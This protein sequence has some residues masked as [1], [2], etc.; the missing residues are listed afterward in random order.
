[1]TMEDEHH[2]QRFVAS[3][4]SLGNASLDDV[5]SS[6]SGDLHVPAE[7]AD[8]DFARE[9]RR[10]YTDLY[11]NEHIL[12]RFIAFYRRNKDTLSFPDILPD[13]EARRNYARWFI[14]PQLF[15]GI[16]NPGEGSSLLFSDIKALVGETPVDVVYLSPKVFQP[17]PFD[18]ED[19]KWFNLAKCACGMIKNGITIGNFSPMLWASGEDYMEAQSRGIVKEA[20]EAFEAVDTAPTYDRP[21]LAVSAREIDRKMLNAFKT[22][23][24]SRGVG[25]LFSSP[26]KESIPGFSFVGY[27]CA[28]AT[29][30]PFYTLDLL[31]WF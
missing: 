29:S 27:Y 11:P 6:F 15:L 23:S 8:D 14:S 16:H 30:P 7:N 1:M 4:V 5:F 9:F 22:F 26:S 13:P 17:S 3:H 19:W 20:N 10:I 28:P 2:L 24:R 31:N 12:N 18:P 21:I 25:S